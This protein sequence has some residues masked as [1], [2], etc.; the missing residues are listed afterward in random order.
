[1]IKAEIKP[2]LAAL[3]KIHM[4]EIENKDLRNKIIKNHL[5]LLGQAKKYN[6][7]IDDLR[8]VHL[9][10]YEEEL[11]AVQLLQNQ[12]NNEKDSSKAQELA[13][14]INSHTKLLEAINAF[15]KAVFDLDREEVEIT[16]IDGAAFAEEY[17][18]QADYDMGV[19][20]ALF[21]MFE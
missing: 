19:V 14:E 9:G 11:M 7:A 15:N 5:F 6:E 20:E 3:K 18:N 17:G 21:P 1:M 8:T 2:A 4:P 10:A 13:K 12:L 16:K